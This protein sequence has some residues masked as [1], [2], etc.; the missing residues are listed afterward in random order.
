LKVFETFIWFLFGAVLVTTTT[1]I[2]FV[3]LVV[4]VDLLAKVRTNRKGHKL[5]PI[6]IFCV[7]VRYVRSSTWQ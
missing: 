6:A 2:I 3:V 7:V 4:V 5:S 1:I